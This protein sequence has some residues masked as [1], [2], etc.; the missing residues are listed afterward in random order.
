MK[1]WAT[2]LLLS[3]WQ[4]VWILGHHSP[5]LPSP[6]NAKNN[7]LSYDSWEAIPVTYLENYIRDSMVSSF[8]N[9]ASSFRWHCP[10]G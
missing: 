6:R 3:T 5:I 2:R 7:S 8:P 4:G 10:C 1:N 9:S